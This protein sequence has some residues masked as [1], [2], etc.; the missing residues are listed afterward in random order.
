MPGTKRIFVDE[1]SVDEEIVYCLT[2]ETVKNMTKFLNALARQFEDIVVA[3]GIGAEDDEDMSEREQ[4]LYGDLC[5]KP[6]VFAVGEIMKRLENE[7]NHLQVM[8]ALACMHDYDF[9]WDAIK[10]GIDS[11]EDEK[12]VHRIWRLLSKW[13][14]V[15]NEQRTRASKKRKSE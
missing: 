10:D 4:F 12:E 14:D 3:L 8:D 2:P 5:S 1:P 6:G 7:K 13:A 11:E 15:A 9:D